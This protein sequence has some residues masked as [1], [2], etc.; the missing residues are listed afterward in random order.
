MKHDAEIVSWDLLAEAI[1]ALV[2][3]SLLLLVA[4]ES[5]T[6]GP[7]KPRR[8]A[9]TLGVCFG[10]PMGWFVEGLLVQPTT[11][12][13]DYPQALFLLSASLILGLAVLIV[14]AVLRLA[15]A[16]APSPS[17][18]LVSWRVAGLGLGMI[19]GWMIVWAGVLL[20][21]STAG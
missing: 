17:R 3:L 10:I 8:E 13:P 5:L 7:T 6:R 16:R 4:R 14:A 20:G 15:V 2:L 11:D 12:P 18:A 9:L 19:G 21:A 1:V